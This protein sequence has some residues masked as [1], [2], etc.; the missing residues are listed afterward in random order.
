MSIRKLGRGRQVRSVNNACLQIFMTV[1]HSL[2][3]QL[4]E[5]N[6]NLDIE[7]S[8]L[9]EEGVESVD[10]TQYERTRPDEEDEEDDRVH[11]SD[12]D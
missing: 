10:V 4:F 9:V 2:G 5:R 8:S 12:S 11:F 3:R 6:R 7:D 1:F